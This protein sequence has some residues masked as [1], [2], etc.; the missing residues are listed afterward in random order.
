MV[1][2]SKTAWIFGLWCGKVQKSPLGIVITWFER[3]FDLGVELVLRSQFFEYLREILYKHALKLLE[4]ARPEKKG[5]FFLPTVNA[6]L[7]LTSLKACDWSGHISGASGSPRSLTKKLPMSPS[8]TAIQGGQHESK[9][10]T[11]ELLLHAAFVAD[12][13]WGFMLEPARMVQLGS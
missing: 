5:H 13:N 2:F 4:V 7:L 6:G 1:Y 12:K 3:I 10:V 8:S 9:F 11:F